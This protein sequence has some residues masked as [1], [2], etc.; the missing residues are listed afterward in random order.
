MRFAVT[1]RQTEQKLPLKFSVGDNQFKAE[2]KDIQVATERPVTEYYEGDYE[3][4]PKREAQ[5]LPTG[6][7]MLD[8]DITV[9]PIPPEYGLVSYDNRKIITIT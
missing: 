7:K 2:F 8:K 5:I 9:K 3:V 6:G 4:T 1:F